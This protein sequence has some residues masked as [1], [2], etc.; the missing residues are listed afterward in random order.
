MRRLFTNESLAIAPG[1]A[2][3]GVAG[4]S[5]TLRVTGGRAWITVEGVSHDYWLSAGDTFAVAPGRLIVIE[6]DPVMGPV[7]ASMEPNSST[8]ALL[9]LL[10][11]RQLQHFAYRNSAKVES[12]RYA[13]TPCGQQMGP[14]A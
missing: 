8:F 11:R 1:D 9:A 10:L 12:R 3:S 13:A 2:V 6:A 5:Q 7:T 4:Q 14:C